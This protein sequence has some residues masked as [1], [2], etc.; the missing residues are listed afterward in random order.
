MSPAPNR[1]TGPRT[2]AGIENCKYNATKHGLTGAQIIINGEDPARYDELR[3]ALLAEYQPASEEESMLVERIAQN[4]WKL[5][6][7]ER[8]ERELCNSGRAFSMFSNDGFTSFQR[9]RN[10]VE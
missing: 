4:W 2:A 7:A 6:R 10:A 8:Y 5:Q 1:S 3:A 9:H